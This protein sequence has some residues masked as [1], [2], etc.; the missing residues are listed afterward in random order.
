MS[1]TRSDTFDEVMAGTPRTQP[2]LTD[3][4]REVRALERGETPVPG[5]LAHGADGPVVLAGTSSLEGWPGWGRSGD[6]VLAV[7]DVARTPNG[8]VAVLPWCTHRLDDALTARAPS[9]GQA[10]TLA[11]SLL[12]GAQE[13]RAGERGAAVG[14][15]GSWWAD[16]GGRPRFAPDIAKGS[17]GRSAAETAIAVLEPVADA[18][19]DRVVRRLLDRVL[20]LLADPARLAREGEALEAELFE[21]CAPQPLAFGDPDGTDDE[22]GDAQ[23]AV[24][25]MGAMA[26]PTVRESPSRAERRARASRREGRERRTQ[27]ARAWASA[28]RQAATSGRGRRDTAIAEVARDAAASVLGAVRRGIR[29]V[30]APLANGRRAAYAVGAAAAIGVLLVGLL[31][32]RADEPAVADE[33]SSATSETVDA[34]GAAQGDESAGEGAHTGGSSTEGADEGDSAGE[35]Q[36]EAEEGRGAGEGEGTDDGESGAGDDAAID[37]TVQAEPESALVGLVRRAAACV[38]AGD[39]VCDGAV[40]REGAALESAPWSELDGA[41][42]VLIDDYGGAALLRVS[43]RGETDYYVTVALHDGRWLL[44]DAYAAAG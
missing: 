10:V 38:D 25:R 34:E 8:H 19:V 14:P 16:D 40:D 6:H 9:G 2:P 30:A 12:R 26:E 24:R 21:A 17:N 27:T 31:W 29:R 13:A 36:G 28:R 37:A 32:P 41:D 11:V 3:A 15:P 7:S 4:Y 33:G 42:I 39:D 20:D 43:G 18:A 22:A 35:E 44:R 5:T 1:T 23:G